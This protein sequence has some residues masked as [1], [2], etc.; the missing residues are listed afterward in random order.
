MCCPSCL[1]CSFQFNLYLIIHILLIWNDLKFIPHRL[2]LTE[3]PTHN[4]SRKITYRSV[5]Q[6]ESSSHAQSIFLTNEI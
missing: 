1:F 5:K 3:T 2:K 6:K 4:M